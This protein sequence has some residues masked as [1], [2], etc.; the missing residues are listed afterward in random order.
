MPVACHRRTT[1]FPPSKRQNQSNIVS[2]LE[3]ISTS[4]KGTSQDGRSIGPEDP[5]ER[6]SRLSYL[7]FAGRVRY[8]WYSSNPSG[9]LSRDGIVT[10]AAFGRLLLHAFD[11]GI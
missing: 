1:L 10:R 9:G 3:R 5:Q 6:I 4:P 11:P 7:T 8:S 2:A